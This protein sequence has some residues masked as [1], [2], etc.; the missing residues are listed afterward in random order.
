MIYNKINLLDNLFLI[1]VFGHV[2]FHLTPLN[3]LL[4]Y[5]MDM[6]MVIMY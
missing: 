4:A 3:Y 6:Y 2:N 5:I 1:L